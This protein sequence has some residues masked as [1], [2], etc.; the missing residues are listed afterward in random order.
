MREKTDAENRIQATRK[1]GKDFFKF[2]MNSSS[3][4]RH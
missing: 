3:K 2:I 1:L 4:M